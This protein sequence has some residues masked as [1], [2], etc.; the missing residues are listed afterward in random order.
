MSKKAKQTKQ[1]RDA[2]V[3]ADNPIADAIE[4]YRAKFTAALELTPGQQPEVGQWELLD[5][6]A[7]AAFEADCISALIMKAEERNDKGYDHLYARRDRLWARKLKVM[8]ELGI[9]N[10]RLKEKTVPPVTSFF[11]G[12]GKPVI[13]FGNA[14]KQSKV[15]SVRPKKATVPKSIDELLGKKPEV[16]RDDAP[17]GNRAESI[18]KRMAILVAELGGKCT[19]CGSTKR[20]EP[21]H[22]HG[23]TWN[24]EEL[25]PE[26]RMSAYEADAKA[27]L[28]RLLCRSCNARDGAKN[29][30]G[31]ARWK[32][33]V[34]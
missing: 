16:R 27:G 10:P 7:R 20:L 33:K 5:I 19:H 8:K 26:R 25:S 3:P 4:A 28:I 15:I 2:T 18:R 17:R 34:V 22:I 29:R 11:D 24:P 13:P 30:Q 31:K 23:T 9:L 6:A 21:D 14:A 32:Q 1:S 12:S